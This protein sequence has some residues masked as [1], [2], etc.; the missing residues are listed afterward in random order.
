M[1]VRT[2][3]NFQANPFSFHLNHRYTDNF[4]PVQKSFGLFLCFLIKDEN[5]GIYKLYQK[6][7]DCSI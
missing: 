4:L 2:K 1:A 6:V 7:L 3:E 5:F